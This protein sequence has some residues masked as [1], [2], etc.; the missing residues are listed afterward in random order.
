[1]SHRREIGRASRARR[2]RL[3]VAALVAGC[4]G[5]KREPVRDAAVDANRWG[6]ADVTDVP[7]APVDGPGPRADADVAVEDLPAPDVA[8][9]ARSGDAGCCATPPSLAPGFTDLTAP[10]EADRPLAIAGSVAGSSPEPTVGLFE[11]L[12]GDG[13]TEVVL[14]QYGGTAVYRYAA[15]SLARRPAAEPAWNTRGGP[16]MAF[17]DVDGDGH[18]DAIR[19][20]PNAIIWGPWTGG[21]GPVTSIGD[22]AAPQSSPQFA[23]EDVDSDGWLDFVLSD[24][25][26]C[27]GCR[28]FRPVLRVGPREYADRVD[29]VDA[30]PQASAQALMVSRMGTGELVGITLGNNCVADQFA[31]GFYRVS[32]VGPDGYPRFGLFDPLPRDC[33]FRRV[34]VGNLGPDFPITAVAPM[35]GVVGDLDGD[36]LFD[37]VLSLNSHA[38]LM[39][40]PA[41]PFADVSERTGI[42][43]QMPYELPWGNA[44][45]DLD[46]DGRADFVVAHGEDAAGWMIPA[47]PPRP[48]HT[49][50]HWNA[51]GTRFVDVTADSGLGR[52]GQW[53]ALE[54]GDLDG[55]ADAD[56][57]IGGQGEPARVYRNDI[58]TA[59]R[60]IALHFRGTSSNPL[61]IGARVALEVDGLPTQHF[62]VG[63]GGSPL[64]KWAPIVFAGVGRASSARRVRVTWPTGVVQE[65]DGLAAGRHHTIE[66]PPLFAVDPPDRRVAADG[67]ARATLRVT[68]R[69]PAGAVDP[70]ATVAVAVVY[71]ATA[72]VLPAVRGADGAWVVGVVSP[73]RAGS[74]VVEIRVNGVASPVRPRIWWRAP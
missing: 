38:F 1:M 73:T 18:D 61:G 55:D 13:T 6:R 15:G 14:T 64:L 29:L 17:A 51:G 71:G 12:D 16:V 63:V 40:R 20:G 10:I 2:R 26:C 24:G 56:L 25:Y 52:Y 74:S 66:E 41:W 48:M 3:V 49:T 46:L 35:G 21:P 5:E 42:D 37:A 69:T 30:G 65:V 32:R 36:G 60:P 58:A 9:D 28:T 34:Y 70:A 19:T 22:P 44:L 43:P 67:A 31:T 23:M 7:V 33:Y 8:D 27:P 68:P 50:V 11:D 57:I 54:V 39:G 53:M 4:F 47:V 59:N 45:L 62:L 72:T